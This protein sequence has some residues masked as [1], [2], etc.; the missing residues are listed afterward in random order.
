MMALLAYMNLCPM[1]GHLLSADER[2]VL[3]TRES[4][5]G[6]SGEIRCRTCGQTVKACPDPGTG[7]FL[8]YSM[9]VKSGG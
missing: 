8:V 4:G 5:A 7:K 6:S 1:S 3:R 9:H 2:E